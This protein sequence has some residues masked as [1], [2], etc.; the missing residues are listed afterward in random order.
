MRVNSALCCRPRSSPRATWQIWKMSPL[1]AA[2]KRFIAYSGEV[3]RKKGRVLSEN[4]T[5]AECMWTS[6]T[7]ELTI[8]GVSTS[9]TPRSTKK[10]RACMST[11]ARCA[12]MSRVAVGFHSIMMYRPR[13]SLTHADPVAWLQVRYPFDG[14]GR[15]DE[16]HCRSHVEATHLSP[17]FEAQWRTGVIQRQL[18][19]RSRAAG[20]DFSMPHGI[21]TSNKE[22]SYQHHGEQ[23]GSILEYAAYSLVT[24]KQPGDGPRC[25]RIDTEQRTGHVPG[26][27][28]CAAQRHVEAMIIE[29]REILSA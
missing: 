24:R 20:S 17:F 25:H 23:P 28:Q 13:Q 8:I 7:G 26:G 2:S 29:R 14:V 19:A 10:W 15:Q 16:N 27:T 12:S 9:S 6:V 4:S 3:C 18:Q 11:A 21:H 1:P 22:R 5:R